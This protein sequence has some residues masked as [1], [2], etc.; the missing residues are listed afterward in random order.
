MMLER[1]E[2]NINGK[3]LLKMFSCK[4]ASNNNPPQLRKIPPIIPVNQKHEPENIK[5]TDALNLIAKEYAFLKENKKNNTLLDEDSHSKG[6]NSASLLNL[7]AIG[8]ERKNSLL[9]KNNNDCNEFIF[10]DDKKFIN[11]RFFKLLM[12]L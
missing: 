6:N 7:G 1:Y 11:E 5:C 9:I 4:Y 8:S 12:D 3:K 2:P 10:K